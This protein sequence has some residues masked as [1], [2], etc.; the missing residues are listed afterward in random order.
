MCFSQSER[1]HQHGTKSGN[2]LGSILI[3]RV[4]QLIPIAF[5]VCPVFMVPFY[6]RRGLGAPFLLYK[7]IGGSPLPDNVYLN[8]V[9]ALGKFLYLTIGITETLRTISCSIILG[10]QRLLYYTSY[11]NEILQTCAK[12]RTNDPV[13]IGKIISRY[14][15]LQ[16][17]FQCDS[18]VVNWLA[19]MFFFADFFLALVINFV[20]T[21]MFRV[22][23]FYFYLI[24]PIFA[25]AI[26]IV[27]PIITYLLLEVGD[28]SEI[29]V[30]QMSLV[31][32][33]VREGKKRKFLQKEVKSMKVIRAPAGM[34]NSQFVLIRKAT[35]CGF[36][37][38]VLGNTI[39][40]LLS[41]HV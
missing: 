6:L 15:N 39:N 20:T 23:P 17:I 14:I 29:V 11:V 19:G 33:A 24:F 21:K 12:N 16:I 25:G 26:V 32:G 27:T 5:M 3:L 35:I 18:Y 1:C 30:K 7:I 34:G 38:H 10:I 40:L 22:L 31:V 36:Y 37:Y 13:R 41:V 8:F 9:T 28:V 2:S 4:F